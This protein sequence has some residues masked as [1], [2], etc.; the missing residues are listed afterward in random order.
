[1]V[2]VSS[3]FII[4]LANQVKQQ[5]KDIEDLKNPIMAKIK[6]G[7]LSYKVLSQFTYP[8]ITKERGEQYSRN[9]YIELDQLLNKYGVIKINLDI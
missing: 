3:K 8:T 7:T 6:N 4:K 1:M 2:E 9:L 5:G